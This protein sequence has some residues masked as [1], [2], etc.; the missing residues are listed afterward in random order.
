[1]ALRIKNTSAFML[2]FQKSLGAQSTEQRGG[3]SFAERSVADIYVR[4]RRERTG[5]GAAVGI[6]VEKL[7]AS[8]HTSAQLELVA[9]KAQKDD[10]ISAAANVIDPRA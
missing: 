7:A 2:S 6:D 3:K 8:R 1:M 4:K 10:V 5:L 9:R